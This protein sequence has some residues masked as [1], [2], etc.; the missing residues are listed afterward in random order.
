MTALQRRGATMVVPIATA[1]ETFL[2]VALEPLFLQERLSTA[3]LGGGG[4]MA[5]PG[6]VVIGNGVVAR[7]RVGGTLVA[8]GEPRAA[9]TPG[10]RSPAGARPEAPTAVSPPPATKPR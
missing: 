1:V 5:G 4:L 9:R 7:T 6:G 10:G 8:G 3:E 2:P